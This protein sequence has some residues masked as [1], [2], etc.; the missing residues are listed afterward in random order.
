M[1]LETRSTSITYVTYTRAL[2]CIAIVVLHTFYGAS[3]YAEG[4]S[5]ILADTV[6][7]LMLWAVPCFVMVTGTLLLDAEH[8]VTY[9]KIFTKYIP[10]MLIALVV[11]S[12]LFEILDTVAAGESFGLS[13]LWSGIKIIFSGDGWNHMWYLYLMIAIYLLLPFYRKISAQLDTKDSYYLLGVYLVFLCIVPLIEAL[14]GTSTAFYICVYTIYP[15][16]L[17]AGFAITHTLHIPRWD[18]GIMAILGTVGEGILTVCSALCD[19]ETLGSE[20]SGYS[21]PLVVLQGVGIYGWMSSIQGQ[22]PRILHKILTEL[23]NC[24]F[25]IY[26]LHMVTLKCVLVY[27]GWNPYEHGGSWM[28][29]LLTL[30]VLLVTFLVV[31]LLKKIPGVRKIL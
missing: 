30:G 23:D 14:T 3:A 9:H 19:W 25:G 28:V 22:A 11:F 31:W 10:R 27:A 6:R 15:F 5:L 18:Y 16:Y 2:A 1:K 7:N 29:L 8:E 21:F 20:L 26:L 13:T 12:I 24:S 17:F 4:T